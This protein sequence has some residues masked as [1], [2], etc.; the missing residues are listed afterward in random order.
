MVIIANQIMTCDGEGVGGKA[1][2]CFRFPAPLRLCLAKECGE[3]PLKAGLCSLCQ[4]SEEEREMSVS[5]TAMSDFIF[6]SF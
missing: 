3:F 5:L 4:S 1:S 2:L 6:T